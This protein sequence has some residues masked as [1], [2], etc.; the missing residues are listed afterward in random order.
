[1]TEKGIMTELITLFRSLQKIGQW[2]TNDRKRQ[3]QW[4]KNNE[5]QRLHT[6]IGERWTGWYLG[7]SGR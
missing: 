2:P 6:L 1:M 5:K 3:F 4:K 7:M